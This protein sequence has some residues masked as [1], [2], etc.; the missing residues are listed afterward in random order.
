MGEAKGWG[1]PA[2]WDLPQERVQGMGETV[3]Q[4]CWP[5]GV[6][7]SPWDRRSP[8]IHPPPPG[9]PPFLDQGVLSDLLRYMSTH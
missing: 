8:L 9:L 5:L 6:T 3:H 4:E 7:R 1:A 2:P